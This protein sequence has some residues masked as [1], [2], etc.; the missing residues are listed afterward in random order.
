MR[1][2]LTGTT[3]APQHYEWGTYTIARTE[4]TDCNWCAEPLDLGDRA[5][6]VEDGSTFCS[7]SCLDKW[8]ERENRAIVDER[9]RD[10]A[11]G[12]RALRQ[13]ELAMRQSPW[14][15]GLTGAVPML[16]DRNRAGELPS[17]A[18]PGGYPILYLVADGETLCPACANGKH[19]SL[20]S[21]D[22]NT[23]SDWRIVGWYIH[24]EGPPERCA[25]CEH[26]TESA[27]GADDE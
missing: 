10:L 19:G 18:W 2:R 25:H 1:K 20:A 4:E 17:W 8:A 12:D 3:P 6:G 13:R 22:E 15:A 26:E 9:E 23:D 14:G 11:E 7:W 5:F 24:W 21:A 27:Y 16:P